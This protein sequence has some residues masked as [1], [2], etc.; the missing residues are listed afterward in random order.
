M[1]VR[2]GERPLTGDVERNPCAS[3]TRWNRQE[4]SAF[5]C[6]PA[7]IHTH[8]RGP[9]QTGSTQ[10]GRSEALDSKEIVCGPLLNYRRMHEGR[11]HG[12]V[13]IVVKGG[14]RQLLH[15]PFLTLRRVVPGKHPEPAAQNHVDHQ[16]IEDTRFESH[17]LYSDPRNT[18]WAFDVSVPIEATETNYEY[19]IPDM[20][21]STDYK[22][23]INNFF[24]PAAAESMRIM[25]HSCNGF[26]V[27]TDEAAWSG[28]A[29]WND[30]MRKHKAR[31]WHVMIGGG[32]QIY[33]DGIRVDGPL[34]QWTD[35]GNPKKRRDYPF[36]EM[37][38]VKCDEYHLKNYIRWYNTEP[39]ALANGQIPQINIWDDHD[40]IDG[41]GSYVDYFMRCDVFRGIGGTAHKY[42]MLFQHHLPPPTSTYTSE[43]APIAEHTQEPD[44]NQLI[45]TY[46]APTKNDPLYIVGP[47][48]GPYVA[49]HSYNL[50]ARLGARI[51]LVGIDARTERTRHQVNYPETYEVVFKKLRLELAAAAN[52]GAPIKHLILL[53]GIPIAYPRLTW[54]ENIFR[55]PVMGPVKFLNRR[56]GLGGALFNHFD[57]SI[58]LLDDLDDHYTS[59]TH[60]KERAELMVRLQQVAADFS[61]RITILGGDVHLAAL[62]RFYSNPDLQIPAE[63]DHRYMVNVISS[64]IVNEPPPQAVANL[65]AR[66]NKIH[67]MN[68]ETDDTLLNLF[69]KDPGDSNKTAK[70]NHCTMPS[71]NFATITEN[72]P[73]SA[74][75]N[76]GTEAP[77]DGEAQKFVD[78]DGHSFLHKGEVGAG[79][80]HKAAAFETHGAGND[81]TLDVCINVEINQHDPEGR[82]EMYGLTIP[83]LNYVKREGT[84]PPPAT[85]DT[86]GEQ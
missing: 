41:F 21:F 47:K 60:K 34:R 38:R 26:S 39:F 43:H 48:P 8:T 77:L 13:L 22:P 75:A 57:G 30:V 65:L 20:R 74:S 79:T 71:R 12:S 72:S 40:I 19:A 62:G 59:R 51:A 6:H 45:D 28:P 61:V 53:L 2:D 7:R 29:L 24:V 78:N 85:A 4:S 11:W 49:E 84:K 63:E 68:H 52:S 73:N 50:Y 64:A 5:E 35:I 17:C 25:F 16:S 56:F 15:Q 36:P 54:L 23:R 82:T 80:A 69:N 10:G 31:P 37:L 76:G 1:P 3:T 86:I 44:P 81:G 46:V 32:D 66:R 55:S 42:Y 67:H 27:G 58:D 14:G 33:N 70:N 18:F 9:V 83:L